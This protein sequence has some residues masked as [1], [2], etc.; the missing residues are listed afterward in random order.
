M[1]D[2]VERLVNLAFYLA[3][4]A[5]PVGVARI[6]AEVSGYGDDQDDAAFARMF[7]R[8]KELLREA[9]FAFDADER[10]AYRLDR[11]ATFATSIDLT[12][13]ES[14]ALRAAGTAMAG[15]PS[16]P[17]A[18]ELR[19]AL[20]KLGGGP[21]GDISAEAH[22]ADEDPE[23]QADVVAVLSAAAS[24]RKLVAFGYTNSYG[25]IAIREIEPYGLFVH[26]GRWY[27]VGRDTARD[28]VRTY[29]VARM[30]DVAANPGRPKAPD[31]ER[32]AGFD[33][34]A[35]VSLPF[36]YGPAEAQFEATV[37]FDAAAAWRANALAGSDSALADDGD[38]V[39]W[40][41]PARSAERLARA[42]IEAGPGVRV[43]APDAAVAVAREGLEAVI[44]DHA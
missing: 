20:A 40:R 41:V 34:R 23:R 10:G 18:D 26:D 25:A 35:F 8:D 36:Q 44:R 42:A 39:L 43:V 21:A 38:G 28:D 15:D 24:A 3:D 13:E 22:L 27:A 37:R 5:E 16:F 29:A 14:A 7:E 4:A 1:G 6:R 12:A 2:A 19:L 33:V 9:G 31:F 30:A 11:D 17:F 32:P